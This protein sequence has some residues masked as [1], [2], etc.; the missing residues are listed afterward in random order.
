MTAEQVKA[1]SQKALAAG[2]YQSLTTAADLVHT[3][4]TQVTKLESSNFLTRR[5]GPLPGYVWGLLGFG[6]LAL[7][8]VLLSGRK[9]A[10]Q[11]LSF[12]L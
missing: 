9:S 12:G 1:A 6:A 3:A 8:Y 5:Y 7:G 10:P 4:G 2:D 11:Q